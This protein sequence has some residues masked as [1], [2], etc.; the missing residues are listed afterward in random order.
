MIV[1]VAAFLFVVWFL[2]LRPRRGGKDAPPMVL[3]SSV[4]PVP[5]VGVL[6]EFFKSP[7]SM[8]K[9]C[10]KDYGPVFTIPVRTSLDVG[11]V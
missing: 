6:A 2:L 3:D 9:R 10:L 1:A 4:V 11:R 5:I 8:V 7:N